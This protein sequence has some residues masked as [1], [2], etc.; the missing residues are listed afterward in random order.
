MT[1]KAELQKQAA[2][3]K[4]KADELEKQTGLYAKPKR[5]KKWKSQVS[6]FRMGE[7][8]QLR[9]AIDSH[10]GRKAGNNET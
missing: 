9:K 7:K 3:L 2:E 5:V 6:I 10:G 4:A 8:K 1:Q